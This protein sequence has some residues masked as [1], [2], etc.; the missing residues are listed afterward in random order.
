MKNF[1]NCFS[2]ILFCACCAIISSCGMLKDLTKPQA[3]NKVAM[4]CGINEFTVEVLSAKGNRATGKVDVLIKCSKPGGSLQWQW[5][6]T[7]TVAVDDKGVKSNPNPPNANNREHADFRTF[8]IPDSGSLD[9]LIRGFSASPEATM[10]KTLDIAIN[11]WNECVAN[12][13]EIP[14]T[15]E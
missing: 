13:R 5:G 7:R 9:V 15:W 4:K 6:D 2:V 1:K 10:F 11:S 14:I 8:R 12:F 3:T